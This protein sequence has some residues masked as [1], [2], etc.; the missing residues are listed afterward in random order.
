ML[1]VAVA[2]ALCIGARAIPTTE[3]PSKANKSGKPKHFTF[4]FTSRKEQNE[5]AAAEH[6]LGAQCCRI[7][8]LFLGQRRETGVPLASATANRAHAR[9]NPFSTR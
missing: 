8:A 3:T 6:F 1:H 2:A 9:L 4:I 7:S 5:R